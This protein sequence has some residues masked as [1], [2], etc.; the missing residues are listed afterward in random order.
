MAY[1]DAPRGLQ[2]RCDELRAD[3]RMLEIIVL[4][5]PDSDERRY[6]ETTSDPDGT[7]SVGI[8]EMRIHEVESASASQA[9]DG[10][11]QGTLHPSPIEAFEEAGEVE[12]RR[13]L[14]RHTTQ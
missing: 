14:H 5:A 4:Q 7:N 1:A 10:L 8:T 9:C 11:A 3:A 12:H 6:V 2:Q 13:V